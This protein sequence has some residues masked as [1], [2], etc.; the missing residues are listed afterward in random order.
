MPLFEVHSAASA[1]IVDAL[2][3]AEA[4]RTAILLI[5]E[6]HKASCCEES[7]VLRVYVSIAR[8]S[9]RVRLWLRHINTWLRKD[10]WRFWMRQR[11]ARLLASD[12]TTL[13]GPRSPAL[14]LMNAFY[15][16]EDEG[17]GMRPGRAEA[18]SVDPKKL[19]SSWVRT[20][21]KRVPFSACLP[22]K[23]KGRL[24]FLGRWSTISPGRRETAR[25][26]HEELDQPTS[27]RRPTPESD[28]WCSSR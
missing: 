27:S 8:G 9:F 14:L 28:R 22:S 19:V 3:A 20:L 12:G 7:T 1:G 6:L 24:A 4:T 10:E 2:I 25:V 26:T 13:S 17:L 18:P 23:T 5:G 16:Y 11:G 21:C 15:G